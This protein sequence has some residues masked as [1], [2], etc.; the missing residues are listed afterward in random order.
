MIYMEPVSLGW[1]P[2]L[3]SWLNTLP[4][5]INDEFHKSMLFGL[6]T[7]FCRPIIWLLQKGGGVKEMAVTSPAN[8]VRAT[9][10]LYDCFMD[11]FHDEKYMAQIS[12]LDVR[13]QMEGVFF[14]S[15]IW[16]MGGT[17]TVD[18]RHKFDVLFRALLEREF[19]Q[20]VADDLGIPFE[21]SKPD[22]PYIFTLPVG[23]SVFDYRYFKE[24]KGK[25][26]LWT[27][28]LAAAPSIP[29]D[30]PVNQIIV[31]TLET[32]RNTEIMKLLVQHQK[33]MMFVGPT[34]TGK[35][36]Y[37]IVIK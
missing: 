8:L 10:N 26:K 30:I 14:F 2:I 36:V 31:T 1:E 19:P 27:D 21:I 20:Q 35:S 17:L 6:F 29:K 15:C 28:E 22:K 9:M 13:A 5:S 16:S 33:A 25:W 4:P 3:T 7:R 34:G 23:D 11:D 18:S 32:I 24:G 37:T 12:D